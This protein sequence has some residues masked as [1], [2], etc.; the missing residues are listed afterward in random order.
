MLSSQEVADLTLALL[1]ATSW[2]EKGSA[3]MRRSWKGYPFE[4]L[5]ALAD[6]GLLTQSRGAKSVWITEE[7]Q[8]RARAIIERLTSSRT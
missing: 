1:Y 6:N 3:D 4:T 2:E 8:E 7:G 5:D